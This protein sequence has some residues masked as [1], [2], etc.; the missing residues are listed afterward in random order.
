MHHDLLNDAR[1]YEPA[2]IS[3]AYLR[4][5]CERQAQ[6]Q[7]H[8]AAIKADQEALSDLLNYACPDTDLDNR[9]VAEAAVM[10]GAMHEAV[11]LVAARITAWKE[12][13]L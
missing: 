4:A 13:R 2:R 10:A 11:A 5:L 6:Q 7:E 12:G 1:R 3:R 9:D 8:V